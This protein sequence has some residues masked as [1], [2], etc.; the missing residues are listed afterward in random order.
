MTR[1]DRHLN[2]RD[3]GEIATALAM[4]ARKTEPILSAIGTAVE[5]MLRRSIRYLQGDS[6]GDSAEY[7]ITRNDAFL[8]KSFDGHDSAKR[9][10]EPLQ[11][12][13]TRE[14]YIRTWVQ[15]I[16]CFT[17]VVD[18]SLLQRDGTLPF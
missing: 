7:H 14:T 16:Y 6:E 13:K 3:Y 5:R 4:L 2:G 9:P 11:N 1:F 8:L 18:R 10:F 12:E 17:R 15:L